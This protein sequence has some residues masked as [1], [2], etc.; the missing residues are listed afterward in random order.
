MSSYSP[1]LSLLL[2]RK[3]RVKEWIKSSGDKS[4]NVASCY[5]SRGKNVPWHHSSGCTTIWAYTEKNWVNLTHLVSQMSKKYPHWGVKLTH[6]LTQKW[7]NLTP[8]WGY[9]L[10]Q[11][12]EL[13]SESNWPSSFLRVRHVEGVLERAVRKERERERE[14][15]WLYFHWIVTGAYLLYPP[16]V[17][18]LYT[19][20]IITAFTSKYIRINDL[21]SKSLK[22]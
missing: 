19:A 1:N 10:G 16:I 8:Q 4:T 18:T 6:Y 21:A 2:T 20:S 9:F 5:S 15:V 3:V 7:V 17:L 12:L 13:S 11:E 14:E 22:R